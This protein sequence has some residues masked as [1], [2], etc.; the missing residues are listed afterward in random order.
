[1]LQVLLLPGVVQ[2]F[3]K[4][5]T[6]LNL[7][8]MIR[9]I[10]LSLVIF[11]AA[12]VVASISFVSC[13]QSSSAGKIIPRDTTI[14]IANAYSNLFM[15][16]LILEKFISK[17]INSDS[18]ALQLR[19]FYNAR[20]YGF[21]WF[22]E[23]G[24]TLQAEGFW[25][26]HKKIVNKS[27]DSSIYD[28][29]LHIQMD[30]LFRGDSL[31][32]LNKDTLNNTEL[33][34]TK[35]FF[36]Y[37][38]YAYGN[39]VD[40]EAVQWH[41]PKRKLQP[42]DLLDSLLIGSA[43]SQPFGKPYQLL[44]KKIFT[45]RTIQQN[46][47][48]LTIE[49]SKRKF[50]SGDTN[51]IITAI[52]KRLQSSDDYD[53]N[54][55]SSLFTPAFET[56]IKKVEAAYGLKVDGKT[57]D[58]LIKKLNIPVEDRI[59]QMLINLERMKWMPEAPSTYLLANIPEYRLHVVENNKE[60][61]G[62]NIVVGKAANR[63]VIFSDDLKYVVF[64]PYWN[65]PRSIVRNEIVPAINRSST[66]LARKNMEVTGYSGGLPVVRQK[67]GGANALGN[68]KFIFPNSYN[69]YF[70]DTPSK[71]LF[72]RQERAFSHGCI[73]LQQP[74][75]LAV[76]L[77]RN[78][79]EWTKE[80]IK[81]AMNSSNEKWVTLNKIVPVFITYFTSWVDADGLLH[82]ADDIY[83]HDKKLAEHLFQ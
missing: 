28:L 43:A 16:S 10:P 41:I 53:I 6:N 37:V 23:N 32:T 17:E 3:I 63:S 33:R 24:P 60:V 49:E 59:K 62:M 25:N 67:P 83:G 31:Y 48:W 12:I 54:D 68:V 1:M 2:S 81:A 9:I 51:K 29:Q 42:I 52:K 80:K 21:A 34:M 14:T 61:L 70:H 39:K 13:R 38:Q 75:D 45:Y 79:P 8:L 47:G 72:S 74:F 78:Q 58:A 35:H 55:T 50:K 4:N 57:D 82:F 40:P 56:A 22:D 65:I 19:N 71:S 66:Y 44:Q 69:I 73:R 26:A 20:N 77:L 76:Y 36:D 5:P 11:T 64:S 18:L 27:G 30:T 7:L 15:D 46:G